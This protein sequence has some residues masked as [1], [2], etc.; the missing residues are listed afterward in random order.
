MQSMYF[1]DTSHQTSGAYTF[2]GQVRWDSEQP[3]EVKDVPA[4]GREFD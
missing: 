3:D 4:Y 2:Q 1:Y